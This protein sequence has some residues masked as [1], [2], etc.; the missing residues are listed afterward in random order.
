[1]KGQKTSL[2]KAA[3]AVGAGVTVGKGLGHIIN[4]VT[5]FVITIVLKHNAEKGNQ[6]AQKIC[7]EH[8]VKYNEQ[9]EHDDSNEVKMG[10]RCQ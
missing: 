8:N 6:Y 4:N 2:F 3:L 7:D 1:M 10:F 9:P 5:D